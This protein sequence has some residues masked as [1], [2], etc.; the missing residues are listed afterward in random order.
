MIADGHV[1]SG[2][3]P[4]P[5]AVP[6]AEVAMVDGAA[7]AEPQAPVAVSALISAETPSATPAAPTLADTIAS[8]TEGSGL[9]KGLRPVQAT[10][11]RLLVAKLHAQVCAVLAAHV[12]CYSLY[13]W[14]VF[15]KGTADEC[16]L[17]L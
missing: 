17:R 15:V 12:Y 4:P 8:L 11:V 2:K 9:L 14:K 10:S 5:L 13:L 7:A 6:V 16:W 1:C 3:P